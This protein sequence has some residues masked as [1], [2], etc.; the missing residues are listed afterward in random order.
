[1]RSWKRPLALAL[2]A[3]VAVALATV[4]VAAAHGLLRV[5]VM[6]VLVAALVG[7][8]LL[9]RYARARLLYD[10]L[11]ASTDDRRCP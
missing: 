10:R 1:M 11:G 7:G 5:L 2:T 8:Y 6:V 9:R 3:A 4:T